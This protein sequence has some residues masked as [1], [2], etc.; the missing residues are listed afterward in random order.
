MPSVR[1]E[2]E[3][4]KKKGI[5]RTGKAVTISPLVGMIDEDTRFVD[6]PTSVRQ[7]LKSQKIDMSWMDFCVWS[8][9]VCRELKR[10]L[11][12]MSNRRRKGK[13]T[14]GGPQSAQE[15]TANYVGV[16]GNTR[17]LSTIMGADKAFRIPCTVRLVGQGDLTVDQSHVQADQGSDMNVISTPMAK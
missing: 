2:T 8:P 3:R 7:L 14:T 5:K 9:A 15:G 16:D 6:K 17:F 1:T 11:T 10:L 13:A 4:P 12:R